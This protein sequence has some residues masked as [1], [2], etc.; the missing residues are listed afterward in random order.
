MVSVIR[1][2]DPD[3]NDFPALLTRLK[4]ACGA[5]GAI[6]DAAIEVQGKHLDRIRTELQ[7]IGYRVKG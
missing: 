1:G 3:G 5:G 4:T 2:L 6:K 7:S